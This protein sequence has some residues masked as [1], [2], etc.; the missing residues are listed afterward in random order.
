MP[1][2]EA[3][4]GQ[5]YV[6]WQVGEATLAASLDAT[7]E[8]AALDPEGRARSRG[9]PVDVLATPGIQPVAPG[10][11]VVLEGPD[12]PLALGADS[13]EGVLHADQTS[14]ADTPSWLQRLP[15]R[16]LAGLLVLTDG[17]IA[18]LLDVASLVAG[19]TS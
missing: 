10:R 7:V 16:H 9:G 15:T 11:A 3:G 5:R 17:R 14:P 18:A 1:R 6:V 2:N 4:P 8:V 12:G 19:D 13:V